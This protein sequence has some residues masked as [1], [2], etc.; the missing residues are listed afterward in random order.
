MK[1]LGIFREQV[2]LLLF[3]L[4][5]NLYMNYNLIFNSIGHIE[6]IAKSYLEQYL[7]QREIA[8]RHRIKFQLVRDL[9]AEAKKKPEKQRLAK[10]KAQLE[11]LKEDA[12]LTVARTWL[13]S[14]K[15]ITNAKE[16]ADAVKESKDLEVN[17]K[18]VR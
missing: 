9:V 5:F 18:Q 15:L 13:K 14:S 7:P 1:K 8:R 4:Q 10:E 17:V 3:V 2:E 16:I 6:Q 12:I 11:E